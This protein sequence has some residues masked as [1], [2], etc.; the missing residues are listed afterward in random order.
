[1]R[2]K[3]KVLRPMGEELGVKKTLRKQELVENIKAALPLA[4]CE[5]SRRLE[6][7]LRSKILANFRSAL[8][9]ETELRERGARYW[10]YLSP[11][12]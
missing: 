6:K 3:M 11:Q 1:M 5:I 7:E 4:N 2:I 8:H 9:D 12:V 10:P